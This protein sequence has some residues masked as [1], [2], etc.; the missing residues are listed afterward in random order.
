MIDAT[1]QISAQQIFNN[2]LIEHSKVKQGNPAHSV[3]FPNPVEGLGKAEPSKP[4]DNVIGKLVNEVDQMNKAAY[5]E[6][7]KVL[8]GETDNIHQS[9]I[10]M[11]EAGVAFSMMVEVRNKLVQSYQEL[12]K[13]PV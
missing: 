1:S 6:S 10:M 3:E 8:L 12:M 13:M 4:F 9:M 5:A 2:S 11:Q 7:N